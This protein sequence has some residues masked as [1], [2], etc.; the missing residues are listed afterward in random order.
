MLCSFFPISYKRQ[1]I[2]NQQFFDLRAI[3]CILHRAVPSRLKLRKTSSREAV[4]AGRQLIGM[5]SKMKL[6]DKLKDGWKVER[7]RATLR[8]NAGIIILLNVFN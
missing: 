6:G 8:Y 1:K 4:E 5:L 3:F 2:I 7:G